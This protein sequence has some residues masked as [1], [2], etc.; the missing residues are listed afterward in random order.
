MRKNRI[1]TTVA[2]VLTFGLG[3]SFLLAIPAR[4]SREIN[5]AALLAL[6]QSG[7]EMRDVIENYNTDRGSLG[8][9]YP[10]ALSPARRARFKQFYEEWRDNLAKIDFDTMGQDGRVDYLLFKNHLDHELRQL[11]IQTK[12][13]AEIEPL[14]P[15][16][17]AVFELDETRRRMAP[18]DSPK[19][20]ALLTDVSKQIEE[21][22]NR[23]LMVGS[24]QRPRYDIH[25][26]I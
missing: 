9:T 5:A 17:K 11:E 13:W 3:S 26:R 15:F 2:L 12:Q 10:D 21:G 18:A 4:A 23:Y 20:A 1:Q 7:S 22:R 14:L 16:A 24:R 8:R 6:D 19:V 25:S